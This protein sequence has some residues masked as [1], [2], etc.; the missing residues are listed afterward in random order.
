MN[1]LSS[2]L[3]FIGSKLEIKTVS[4]SIS[5][6]SGGTINASETIFKK[7]GNLVDALIVIN[8]P[9]SDIAAGGNVFVGKL[10]NTDLIPATGARL[11]AYYNKNAIIATINSSGGIT[12]RNASDTAITPSGN[13]YLAGVYTTNS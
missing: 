1:T 5:R 3:K 13:F 8:P 7:Q 12:V 11:T 4:V 6:T 9:S 10:N 2:I